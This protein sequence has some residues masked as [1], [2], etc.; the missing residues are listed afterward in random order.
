MCN[1]SDAYE[2]GG[3]DALEGAGSRRNLSA[4]KGG[5]I[6]GQH[7]RVGVRAGDC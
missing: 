1:E 4:R 7:H 3:K 2:D 5:C 6:Q